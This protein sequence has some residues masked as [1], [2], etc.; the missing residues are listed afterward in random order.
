[1]VGKAVD[2]TI[3]GRMNDCQAHRGPDD[4][5][6]YAEPTVA[7]G[8]R[9]LS[10][11]DLSVAGHQ[12]MSNEQCFARQRTSGRVWF[13]FNGEIYNFQEL[14]AGLIDRGHL[15]QSQTDSEVILHLYE[16]E[17]EQCVERL[18]GMFAF[19]LWDAGQQRLLLARDRSGEKPLL[20]GI[21][22]STLYFASEIQALL[23][24]PGFSREVDPTALR[25]YF[26]FLHVPQ[27]GCLLKAI[28]K[29][30]PAT[31]LTITNG[32]M[33]ERLY[34]KPSYRVKWQKSESELVEE[35]RFRL[36][37][38]VK[39]RLVSDVPIGSM[40]SGG[41]D[42]TAVTALA[43]RHVGGRLQTFSAFFEDEEGRDP[44]WKF[45]QLAVDR[46]GVEHTNVFYNADDLL[47][48]LPVA[49][50]HYGEPHAIITTLV[51]L[52]L[53]RHIKEHVKVVLS[54]NG[55]DEV[56][57]GYLT[58]KK[59][60]Q[61][62]S[63]AVQRSLD[64]IPHSL[65]RWMRK[66]L[67]HTHRAVSGEF[68]M[69]LYALSLSN[70]MRRSYNIAT[71][72]IWLTTELFSRGAMDSAGDPCSHFQSVFANADADLHFDAWLH[73]DLMSRMQE[74][75]VIQPDISGMTYGLE[76]RAPFLDHELIQFAGGL[77]PDMKVRNGQITKYLLRRA[78]EGI[79]PDE[80]VNRRDK[81]GFSGVTYAHLIGLAQGRWA[82]Y[83]KDSLFSGILQHC[84]YFQPRFIESTWRTLLQSDPR[85]AN[86]TL[87]FQTIW[88]LVIF[89]H[90]WREIM[91]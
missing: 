89:E 64:L 54:G 83:F 15:F 74:Y 82:P 35:L 65:F 61:L 76:I 60:L 79:I 81:T 66:R 88:S 18:R 10:I 77:T 63:P 32:Q 31:T 14:R 55:G 67:A 44:D 29:L 26:N 72:D 3:V 30:P 7:L 4:S 6:L 17:G 8:H 41:I 21:H 28:R 68:G 36:D 16:E 87:L 13:V 22:N 19:G 1:M 73:T 43:Q 69:I 45:A 90:W 58:Y 11:I 71:S 75:T 46:L 51:S 23:S 25:Q 27:P 50:R 39:T 57:G 85:S 5:G 38:V 49:V 62:S 34:W 20:Y 86:A 52:F 48:I 33:S 24:V 59:V 91:S 42:S 78:L 53:S 70:E 56:F 47:N 9:R 84:G 37:D 12:P 80:I 40:L 2:K